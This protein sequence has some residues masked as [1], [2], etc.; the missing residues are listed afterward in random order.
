MKLS[1]QLHPRL[2]A[3]IPVHL[4]GQV[5]NMNKVMEIAKV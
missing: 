2:K 3:I 1:K 4:F 5:A